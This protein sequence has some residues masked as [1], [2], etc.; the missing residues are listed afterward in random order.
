MGTVL[1]PESA[2]TTKSKVKAT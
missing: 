2:N 1:T